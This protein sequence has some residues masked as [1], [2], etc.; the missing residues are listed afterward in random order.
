MPR[1][2]KEIQKGGLLLYQEILTNVAEYLELSGISGQGKAA[3]DEL[4]SNVSCVRPLTIDS[5]Q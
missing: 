2:A 4:S 1:Y 3:F 5:R